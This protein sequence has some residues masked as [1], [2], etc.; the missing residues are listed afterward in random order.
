M[1]KDLTRGCPRRD[2]NPETTFYENVF[3]PVTERGQRAGA[4]PAPAGNDEKNEKGVD[5]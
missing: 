4:R 2:S 3:Y 1:Q 5:K